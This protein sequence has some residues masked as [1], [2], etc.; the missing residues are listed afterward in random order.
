MAYRDRSNNKKVDPFDYCILEVLLK[1]PGVA[2]ENRGQ[3]RLVTV[4][5]HLETILFV[6]NNLDTCIDNLVLAKRMEGPRQ[7]G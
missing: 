4:D 7:K 3:V 2:S 6:Q 1:K 5:N